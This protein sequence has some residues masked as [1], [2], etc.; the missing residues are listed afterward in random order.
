MK[1]KFSVKNQPNFLGSRFWDAIWSGM[2]KISNKS[3]EGVM[4]S[5]VSS[6]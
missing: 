6:A 5:A 1:T 3:G 2:R 4:D